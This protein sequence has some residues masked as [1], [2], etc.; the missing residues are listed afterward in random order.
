MKS[1]LILTASLA[2]AIASAAFAQDNSQPSPETN[3]A[4]PADSQSNNGG[5]Q[6]QRHRH[7]K[8]RQTGQQYSPAAMAQTGSD[9]KHQAYWS[10]DQQ[11]SY[12]AVDH[13]H[14][15]GD[16]PVINHNDDQTPVA[17]PTKTT[18]TIPPSG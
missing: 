12:P 16:P 1:H 2:L 10:S 15:P 5:A 11:R 13:G 14:V 6:Q 8:N 9:P 18:I 4:V 7:A 17:N 3:Q